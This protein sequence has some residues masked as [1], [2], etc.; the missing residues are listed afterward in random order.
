MPAMLDQINVAVERSQDLLVNKARTITEKMYAD[1]EEALKHLDN[2]KLTNDQ[3]FA[4]AVLAGVK[5]SWV[6]RADGYHMVT[7]PCAVVFVDGRV[8]VY[9]KGER[10]CLV[11]N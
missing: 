6:E 3:R 11:V 2:D 1:A 5:W 10:Q 8:K 9:T 7:D 4:L